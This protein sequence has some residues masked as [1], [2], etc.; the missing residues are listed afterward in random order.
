MK[1]KV[2]LGAIVLFASL[3]V[4]TGCNTKVIERENQA[5]KIELDNVKKQ[6]SD[7][8]QQTKQVNEEK[9][10]LEQQIE[11]LKS[12]EVDEQTLPQL[13]YLMEQESR[14][15]LRG[16]YEASI[17]LI[18]GAN[19]DKF[20][21]AALTQFQRALAP[22]ATQEYIDIETRRLQDT[23]AAKEPIVFP[24]D[25]VKQIMLKQK[26]D[27]QAIVEVLITR[28][29]NVTS[30]DFLKTITVEK[31]ELG[32]KLKNTQ[33]DPAPVEHPPATQDDS[34]GEQANKPS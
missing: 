11:R 22:H 21:K 10:K 13:A 4:L 8:R 31:T 29:S 30:Q 27:K 12:A 26:D 23:W 25:K 9:A 1:R 28:S 34:T 24:T 32:W 6:L 14:A 17:P 20:R 18:N 33:T 3:S 16:T 7:S 5:L 19:G 2:K 15:A